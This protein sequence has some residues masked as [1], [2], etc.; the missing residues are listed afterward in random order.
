MIELKEYELMFEYNPLAQAVIDR[1]LKF[2]K[3]N[4][5]FVKLSGIFRR[6]ASC[7]ENYGS[8]DSGPVKISQRFR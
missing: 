7:H 8:P 2:V 5:A 4:T 6:P 1:D 3:V